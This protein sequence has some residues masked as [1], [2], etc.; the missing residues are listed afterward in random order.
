MAKTR[1]NRRSAA[2]SEAMLA[3]YNVMAKYLGDAGTSDEA[4]NEYIKVFNMYPELQKDKRLA[5]IQTQIARVQPMTQAAG[6]LLADIY[7]VVVSS[8]GVNLSDA[9]LKKLSPPALPRVP[10]ITKIDARLNSARL[11]ESTAGVDEAA[12]T[13]RLI[14]DQYSQDLNNAGIASAGQ[15]AA[16][17]SYAQAASNRRTRNRLA[18]RLNERQAV[19]EQTAR[20]DALL[21]ERQR[22]AENQYL[23]NFRNVSLLE[24]RYNTDRQYADVLGRTGRQSRRN[25][26]HNIVSP[27]A[28]TIAGGIA[29]YQNMQPA[30]KPEYNPPNYDNVANLEDATMQFENNINFD[31]FNSGFYGY[32]PKLRY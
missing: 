28:T 11:R 2:S 3:L 27:L 5:S 24:Q 14:N 17:G 25:A 21:A 13:N 26:L 23:N 8:K 4:M 29:Q 22:A 32:N 16:Y 9:Q 6:Q 15:A 10:D 20:V 1:K 31:N 18:G 7:D 19:N 30:V 12:I